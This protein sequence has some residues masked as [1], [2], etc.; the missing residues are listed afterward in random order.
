MGR[1]YDKDSQAN[2]GWKGEKTIQVD[3]EEYGAIITVN[4]TPH[5]KTRRM[6][7]VAR[8]AVIFL[9]KAIRREM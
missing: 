1:L 6:V 9:R 8:K 2:C 5:Q 7:L 4:L 3:E